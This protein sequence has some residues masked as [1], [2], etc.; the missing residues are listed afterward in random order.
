MGKN[1]HVVER[2]R[3]D[4]NVDVRSTFENIE[5]NDWSCELDGDMLNLVIECLIDNSVCYFDSLDTI[6]EY[7]LSIP[8]SEIIDELNN[9]G[10]CYKAT[11]SKLRDHKSIKVKFIKFSGGNPKTNIEDAFRLLQ[12]KEYFLPE[13]LGTEFLLSYSDLCMQYPKLEK[14][15]TEI[16]DEHEDLEL[17]YEDVFSLKDFKQIRDINPEAAKKIEQIIMKH[18]NNYLDPEHGDWHVEIENFETVVVIKITD[19]DYEEDEY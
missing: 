16:E 4:F 1:F 18:T 3:R 15:I 12:G 17:G 9:N 6:I 5:V 11:F 19:E 7:H 14:I 10:G 8:V 2:V 13:E